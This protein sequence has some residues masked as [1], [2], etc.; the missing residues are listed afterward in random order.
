MISF[1][2]NEKTQNYSGDSQK[3]LLDFLRKE[4]LIT[5][6]KDG[7]SGE[8][9]CGAC[10]IEFNGKPKLAC[11]VKMDDVNN[12]NINTIEGLNE[13]V[14]NTIAQSFVDSGAVQC[15][16]CTPGFIMR[17]KVLLDKNPNPA[18]DQIKKA[19][20]TNLCRCTGYSKI[21]DGIQ[22]AGKRLQGENIVINKTTGGVGERLTKYQAYETA[23][24]QRKFTDDMS[25][26]GMLFSALKF[27]DHPKAKIISINTSY[28]SVIYIG[29]L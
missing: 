12:A 27:S 5:S 15:G 8:G 19:I 23:I 2:L 11:K 20:S 21:I 3:S 28:V 13:H 18:V 9:T 16:F 1:I 6:V 22:L 10:L 24:G 7:C 29:C 17:T 4:L 14:K 25:F 26:D